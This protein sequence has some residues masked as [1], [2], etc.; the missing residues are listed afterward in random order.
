MPSYSALFV[1]ELGVAPL[2]HQ[3]QPESTTPPLPTL[4]SS[5]PAAPTSMNEPG[6]GSARSE[7]GLSVI[8]L[9]SPIVP[10]VEATA[11]VA[12]DGS[13][14]EPASTSTEPAVATPTAALASLDISG[15]ASASDC[16]SEEEES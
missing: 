11:V 7:E 3:P 8:D 6:A 4:L 12:G 14:F 9:H 16:S 5:T 10:V 13:V 1:T 15:A 2:S